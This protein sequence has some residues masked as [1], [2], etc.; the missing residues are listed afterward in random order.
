LSINNLLA[1]TTLC[2]IP[3]AKHF[4][5]TI[6]ANTSIVCINNGSIISEDTEG[7]PLKENTIYKLINEKLV[8]EN[9]LKI[10]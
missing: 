2:K 7:N 3:S 10:S 5:S 1:S 6:S 4:I 9:S 8:T